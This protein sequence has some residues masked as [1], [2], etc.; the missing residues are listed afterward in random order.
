MRVAIG[1]DGRGEKEPV[2]AEP[3]CDF[4]EHVS[5]T[6]P[7]PAQVAQP[8]TC[9]LPSANS[10]EID[11]SRRFLEED[12]VRLKAGYEFPESTD[13]VGDIGTPAST[14]SIGAQVRNPTHGEHRIRAKVNTESERR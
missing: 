8:G 13:E 2:V 3:R 5:A 7:S 1:L 9:A 4:T 11:F 6:R 10:S 14:S 12:K